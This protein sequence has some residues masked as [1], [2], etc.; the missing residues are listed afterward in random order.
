MRVF[1][2][3]N[4]EMLD[5]RKIKVELSTHIQ[6]TQIML[7]LYFATNNKRSQNE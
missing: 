4:N 1:R 6:Q 3:T 7:S 5:K 2:T